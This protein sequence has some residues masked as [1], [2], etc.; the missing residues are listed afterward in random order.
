MAKACGAIIC[1]CCG[2][3]CCGVTIIICPL[4]PIMGRAPFGI[5]ICICGCMPIICICWACA[6]YICCCCCCCCICICCCICC[7]CCGVIGCCGDP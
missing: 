6:A 1:I 3:I 5:I 2:D 4:G 7:C